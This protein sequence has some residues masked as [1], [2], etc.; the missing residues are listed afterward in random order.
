MTAAR[1]VMRGPLPTSTA[2]GLIA[3]EDVGHRPP[4]ATLPPA[5]LVPPSR[6]YPTTYLPASVIG[7][8]PGGLMD[9][10]ERPRP[11][12][13]SPAVP[14]TVVSSLMLLTPE[15][16]RPCSTWRMFSRPSAAG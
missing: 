16:M 10:V 7:A 6:R 1:R 2:G 4:R 3:V 15:S 9:S 12:A 13:R 5:R 8:P 14:V 11:Y